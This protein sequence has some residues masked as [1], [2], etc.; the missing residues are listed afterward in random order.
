MKIIPIISSFHDSFTVNSLLPSL[1][2]ACFY[3]SVRNN[4][5]DSPWWKTLKLMNL[6]TMV[7]VPQHPNKTKQTNKRR[8]KN[9]KRKEKR[10]KLSP[11]V[12]PP[13]CFIP[14]CLR[15]PPPLSFIVF[16]SSLISGW[17][18]RI[19]QSRIHRLP[20]NYCKIFYVKCPNALQICIH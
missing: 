4:M 14:H 7:S 15:I 9:F 16:K 3:N 12:L 18:L 8:K 11:W 5:L 1:L 20:K 13:H 19:S 2:Y 17:L 10:P 6:H